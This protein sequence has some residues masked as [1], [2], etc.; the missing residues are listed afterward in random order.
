MQ[1]TLLT[2]WCLLGSA[3]CCVAETLLIKVCPISFA[4]R[5]SRIMPSQVHMLSY[6]LDAG[7]HGREC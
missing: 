2:A 1:L 6:V 4:C 3:A 7:G 5:F